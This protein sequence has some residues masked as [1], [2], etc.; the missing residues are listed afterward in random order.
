MS[1]YK[2]ED[3]YVDSENEEY[4]TRVVVDTCARCFWIYSNEGDERMI[5]CEKVEEFMEVLTLIRAV[6][7]EDM[8]AYNGPLVAKSL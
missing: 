6:V 1:S 2:P 4:M 3:Y 7:D 8:I 5:Q